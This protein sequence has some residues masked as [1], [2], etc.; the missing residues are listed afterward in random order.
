M[1]FCSPTLAQPYPQL[2]TPMTV[3]KLCCPLTSS[4]TRG[5]PLSP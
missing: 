4:V 1:C 3:Q 2:T 5:P